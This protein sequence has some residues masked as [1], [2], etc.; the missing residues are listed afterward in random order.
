MPTDHTDHDA[1]RARVVAPALIEF[2]FGHGSALR[3]RVDAE[4]V[5]WFVAADLCRRLGIANSRDALAG[6]DE[7]PRRAARELA[8]LRSPIHAADGARWTFVEEQPSPTRGRGP[9]PTRPSS[10][11]AARAGAD[12][13]AGRD[14]A[15][16]AIPS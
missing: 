16:A 9:S 4:G 3:A 12:R 7:T 14:A 13:G 10:R 8:Q 1:E 11:R 15:R 6:L 5:P 2:P